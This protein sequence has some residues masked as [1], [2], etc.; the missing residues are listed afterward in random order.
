MLDQVFN[1][2]LNVPL[3]VLNWT[4]TPVICCQLP[5]NSPGFPFCMSVSSKVLYSNVAETLRKLIKI[6]QIP[7]VQSALARSAVSEILVVQAQ[8]G[9]EFFFF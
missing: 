2:G 7:P 4:I 3:S 1:K 5:P 6:V 8:P 9:T